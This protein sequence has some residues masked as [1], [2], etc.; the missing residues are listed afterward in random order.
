MT[1]RDLIIYILQNHLEDE[2]V[3][4]DGKF[5][6]FL[7]TK[8]AAVKF[9]VSDATIHAWMA[10]GMLE[11]ASVTEQTCIPT[12]AEVNPEKLKQEVK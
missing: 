8:E 7:T 4:R 5:I 12:T 1:G 3:V 10:L 11:G 2:E 9:G 6:G